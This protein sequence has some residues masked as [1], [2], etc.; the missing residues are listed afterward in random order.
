M[1]SRENTLLEKFASVAMSNTSDSGRTPDVEA[2]WA[3]SVSGCASAAIRAPAAGVMVLGA[4]M[5][6][7]GI[8]PATDGL[9]GFE[10]LATSHPTSA[11]AAANVP[12]VQM[13]LRAMVSPFLPAHAIAYIG[14]C[15]EN[16]RAARGWD[17]PNHL[18]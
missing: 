3:V 1:P 7:P 13:K 17:A 16:L 6:T 4:V 15:G 5:L 2:F 18:P 8:G 11:S 9:S 10:L 14:R 12:I